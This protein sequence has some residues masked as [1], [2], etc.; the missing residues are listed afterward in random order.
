MPARVFVD[1]NFVISE[2]ALFVGQCA[3]D[4]LFELLDP[5]RFELKYLWARSKRAIYIKERIVSSCADEAEISRFDVGQKNVLLRFV[6]M[7]D[8]I[9]EQD[10][11][12]PG[13]A[14]AIRRRSDDATHFRDIAFHATDSNESCVSFL[15][16]D[17]G[18]RGLSAAGRAR[19]NHWRQKIRFNCPA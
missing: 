19:E 16:N 1:L 3:I 18:K 13:R 14:E 4:Y 17:A 11:L 12:L 10:R 8:L 2:T 6:E 15:G 7:M 9:D 5:E